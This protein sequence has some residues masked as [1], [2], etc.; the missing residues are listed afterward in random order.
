[1]G[2]DDEGNL[3]GIADVDETY[4]RLTKGIRDAIVPDVTMFV[5]YILEE[6]KV[7]RI[8]VGVIVPLLH[9]KG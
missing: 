2:I 6:D 4:T 9:L 8:E 5:R 7:I 1:M 3:K